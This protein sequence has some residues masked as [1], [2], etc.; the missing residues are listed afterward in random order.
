FVDN[1]DRFTKP[2]CQKQDRMTRFYAPFSAFRSFILHCNV[3]G[4]DGFPV[5][6]TPPDTTNQTSGEQL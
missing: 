4:H 6:R 2:A 3:K 1:I 5:E